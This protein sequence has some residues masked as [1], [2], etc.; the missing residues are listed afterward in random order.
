MPTFVVGRLPATTAPAGVTG[1][2]IER[3]VYVDM[4]LDVD[5]LVG[6]TFGIDSQAGYFYYN[7]PPESRQPAAT[8]V[9]LSTDL[10]F[11]DPSLG[12]GQDLPAMLAVLA[13]G[14]LDLSIG[15]FGNPTPGADDLFRVS[16]IRLVLIE[17]DLPN[18]TG[19]LLDDRAHFWGN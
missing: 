16:M 2:R 10:I 1:A 9:T 11:S 8:W 19:Q 5:G 3:Q 13:M 14:Q 6:A 15:G 7:T 4:A 12:D 18:L 17:P